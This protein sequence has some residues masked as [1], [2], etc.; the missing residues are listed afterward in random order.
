MTIETWLL[1]LESV[2]LLATIILLL[3]S[4]KEGRGRKNLL[5]EV[6]RATKV[7]TRQEYFLTVTDSMMDAKTEVIG[8]ITG[9]L[10]IGDDKKRT[11]SVTANIERLTKNGV[12]VRYLMPKFQDRLHIGYMYTKAGAEI[13]YSDCAIVHDIRYMVV[14]DSVVVMGIPESVG[15]KE[16]TRKGY[17]IPSEGLAAILKEHFY[18]CWDKNITFEN[19]LK[20]VIKQTGATPKLL[21]REL[22]IDEEELEKFTQTA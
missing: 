4:L 21:A 10:P 2:L 22:Q 18:S 14:D 3:F 11:K 12:S 5:L 9:R 19:Y 15:E 20:E 16:A 17:R 6:E 13:R 8:A 1:I 7:L